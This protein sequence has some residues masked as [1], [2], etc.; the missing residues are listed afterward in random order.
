MEFL[1]TVDGEP[2]PPRPIRLRD[3]WR[4]LWHGRRDARRLP[5]T[6]E[7]QPP[8]LE[9]LRAEAEA[10]QRTVSGWLH[11]KI[12]AVDRE[13]VRLLT[14]LEQD[15][16]DQVRRPT[17]TVGR[18]APD[19]ADPRPAVAI[20]T[21]VLEARVTAAAQQEFERRVRERNSAEQQL[22]QL[23]SIRHHLLE[24]ARAAA[25]AHISRYEQLVGLYC[26]ALLRRQPNRDLAAAGYRPRAVTSEP[27]VRDDMPLLVLDLDSERAEH[28]RWL[29]K[30]F[31]TH[32]AGPPHPL[33]IEVPRAG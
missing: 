31:A 22:G 18:Q 32:T 23:G 33:P 27:W 16:R 17:P 28:Y 19:D 12:V 2:P 13:T 11:N 29:L 3:R 10:G 30:E 1:P 26:A 9:T 6:A 7:L 4:V 5:V 14:W 8:Y 25:G 21:W 15:R 24:A 20:P